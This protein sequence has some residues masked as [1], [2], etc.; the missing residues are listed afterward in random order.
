MRVDH[1]PEPP[2][3]F[4]EGAALKGDPREPELQVR[5]EVV[6]R[7]EAFDP[8]A[9]DTVL[10]QDEDRRRPLDVQPLTHTGI[11]VVGIA[12]VDANGNEFK[13]D[14]PLD[15][16]VGVH[17]GFQPST[18]ASHRGRGEIDE[19]A[20]LVLL[21]LAQCP[22]GVTPPGDSVFSHCHTLHNSAVESCWPTASRR[23]IVIQGDHARSMTSGPLSTGST[24]RRATQAGAGEAAVGVSPPFACSP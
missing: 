10:V 5:E 18:A 8:V 20:L 21:R 13:R 23:P 4:V 9:L 15:P 11:D 19:R 22:L 6:D 24:G 17:L 7:Q 16:L 3:G 1:L 12:Y 14:E 2:L